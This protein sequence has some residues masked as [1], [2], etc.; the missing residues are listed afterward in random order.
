MTTAP[1]T[2]ESPLSG[3]QSRAVHRI[4][5]PSGEKVRIRIPGI[6]TMLEHGHLPDDL[7]EIAFAEV[8]DTVSVQ[9]AEGPAVIP[10]SVQWV[11]KAEGN[12]QKMERLQA[13][14]RF[15]RHLVAAALVEPTMTFEQVTEATISG[16][17]PEDDL[18]MISEIVQRIRFRDA[19]GV[20]L[21][22]EPLERW[23]AFRET[24]TGI[25]C[26]G[27]EDCP[28]CQSLLDLFST[29]DVGEV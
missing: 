8:V 23:A 24:H 10:G 7:F 11:G 13:Y 15:Q 14:G 29:L 28:A 3:W 18:S 2:T 19:R 17:L 4:T 26:T 20:R 25:A 22:V 27:N 6:A 16:S 12:E 5:L 9:G 21:G 1:E